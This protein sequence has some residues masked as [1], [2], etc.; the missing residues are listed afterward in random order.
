[1]NV[2]VKQER[3]EKLV[4]KMANLRVGQEDLRMTSDV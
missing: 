1:M 4:A 2:A 3:E